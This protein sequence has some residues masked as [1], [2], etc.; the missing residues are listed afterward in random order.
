MEAL[1]PDPSQ[2]R[3][4][5]SAGSAAWRAARPRWSPTAG[6]VTAVCALTTTRSTTLRV[7]FFTPVISDISCQKT[8]YVRKKLVSNAYVY[9]S[10]LSSV[11]LKKYKK[12]EIFVVN[13]MRK[14]KKYYVWMEVHC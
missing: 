14:C 10:H 6:S 5:F 7:K 8:T 4:K 9:E 1:K 2:A 11:F 13:F 3:V 12:T